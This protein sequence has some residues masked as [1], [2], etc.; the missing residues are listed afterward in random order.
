M[1]ERTVEFAAKDAG[2]RD[3]VN[4][5]GRLVG[6]MLSEQGGEA[7][8]A[9]VEKVRAA[10]IARR[11]GSDK[12]GLERELTGLTPAE[13]SELVRAFSAYFQVVNLAE[14]VHRIR[15]RRDYERE[16]KAPQ[17]EGLEDSL[18]K[19]RDMNFDAASVQT[20]LNDLRIDPVFTA[21]P[22]EATRRTVLEKQQRLAQALI[23]RLDPALTPRE[24]HSLLERM[25]TEITSTWQTEEHPEARMTVAN[26]REHVLFYLT[27]ILYRVLPVFYER[28]GEALAHIGINVEPADLPVIV[29]FGSWVGG[30]M[31]GNPNVT[32]ATMRE[33]LRDHRQRVLILY[34]RDLE[35]LYRGLSQSSE[36]IGF[37]DAVIARADD[38]AQ[39]FPEIERK[40][41][42]R[43]TDM[44]Y[45]RLLAHVRARVAASATGQ[46]GAY[47]NADGLLDDLRLIRASLLHHLGRHAGLFA[48]DRLIRKVETF[49][50]HLATLDIRQDALVHRKAVGRL[51][52]DA[53]WVGKS[54]AERTAALR[55]GVEKRAEADEI[56][57]PVLK[58]FQTLREARDE[59]G[60]RAIGPYII[61]MAQG[62]DD[63]FGVLWLAEQ[64]GLRDDDRRIPLDVAPLF[65]TVADLRGA[66][67]VMQGL[68]ED[69]AYRAHLK[70]RGDHQIIMVGYSDS[71]K[72]GGLAAARWA[73]YQAQT[74]LAEVCAQ[75]GVALTIFHGR[76]G[77]TSRGGGRTHRAVLASPAGTV[78]DRLRVTEQGEIIN[79][80]YGLRGIALRTLEQSAGAVLLATA[81]ERAGTK[82]PDGADA[83]MD[84]LAPASRKAFRALVYDSPDFVEY[85]RSATPIDVIE[86][87]K[88]GSR[89]ASRRGQSGVEDLRAIPWVFSWTQ[90]RQ[91]ITGWY[92]LGTGL[93]A[94]AEAHGEELL[95]KL[96]REWRFFDALLDDAEMVLAKSDM[97]IAERYAA[98]AG[99]KLAHHFAA[100]REEYDRT[101]EWIMR[102]RGQNQLLD[103]DP[104]LQRSIRL[105]NPYVDP[106]SLLQVDLLARWREQDRPDGVLLDA[107]FATVNGIAQGL[108]NTG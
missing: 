82:R 107:L 28:L 27:D 99:P 54:A 49:G 76:G 18:L 60:P 10:A 70:A 30:D 61:S 90:S 72:D 31:D 81:K 103:G 87:M 48:L 22:T 17:P 92:G 36:R 6:E 67:D 105:R 26:E 91:I 43:H 94:A 46:P 39:R 98:L 23:E 5:L 24:K 88:I 9:R 77:T 25:R 15:R 2:L 8:F 102:L 64:A 16:S 86:R 14:R 95:C 32:A 41:P 20:L 85:F 34:R 51:L 104:T 37:D 106:M 79:A 13:A 58:V 74:R 42:A 101:V 12:N 47:A 71:N 100:I 56:S 69:P 84:V 1:D 52:D 83:M 108:Q 75:A 78:Q 65:E 3:D 89:P 93:A 45:R 80:K 62:A 66:A 55:A 33:T 53:G 59:Y 44:P 96:A 40:I 35:S 29:R 7:L 50:F 68:F 63:V 73:L 21:H 57:T 19:L 97:P 11:E 38:Y 4:L